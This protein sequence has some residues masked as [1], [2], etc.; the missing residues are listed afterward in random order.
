MGFLV[1]YAIASM[2]LAGILVFIYDHTIGHVVK[3]V[4]NTTVRAGVFVGAWTAVTAFLGSRGFKKS[5]SALRQ[6]TKDMDNEV[7]VLPKDVH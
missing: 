3:N 1:Q 2:V 7:R 4:T 6:K 5:V